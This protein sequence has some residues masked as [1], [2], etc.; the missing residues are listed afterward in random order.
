MAIGNQQDRGGTSNNICCKMAPVYRMDLRIR[1]C[2]SFYHISFNGAWISKFS[3]SPIKAP[4]IETG[5][6]ITP[7]TALLGLGATRTY[8]KKYNLTK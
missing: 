5:A 1:A 4:K 6:L 2:I 7:V 3:N 8:E